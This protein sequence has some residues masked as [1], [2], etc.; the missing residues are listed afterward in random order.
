LQGQAKNYVTAANISYVTGG[1]LAALGV[2]LYIVGT[3]KTGVVA[4]DT[5][6]Q[7]VPFVGRDLA[8]LTA[9]GTW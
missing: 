7:V 6:A 2:A 9:G 4:S 1:T 8:G 3:P 5:H